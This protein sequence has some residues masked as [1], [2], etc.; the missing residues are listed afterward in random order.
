MRLRS[1]VS[2]SYLRSEL[3]QECN[4]LRPQ[5]TKQPQPLPFRLPSATAS[6]PESKSMLES[7]SRQGSASEMPVTEILLLKTMLCVN[8]QK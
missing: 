1:R 8:P 2:F 6:E 5:S 7:W 3:T 4:V